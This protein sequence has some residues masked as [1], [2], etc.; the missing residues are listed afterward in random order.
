MAARN[1][2]ACVHAGPFG[3]WSL[4]AVFVAVVAPAASGQTLWYVDAGAPG[5]GSGTSWALLCN[6]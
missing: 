3:A 1:R 6:S 4:V 2:T 5:G